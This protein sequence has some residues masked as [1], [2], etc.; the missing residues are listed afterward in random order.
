[1]SFSSVAKVWFVVS[2]GVLGVMYGTVANQWNVFPSPQMRTA[3]NQAEVQFGLESPG[4]TWSRTYDREGVR[5]LDPE[6]VQSGLRFI[7]TTWEAGA[8]EPSLTLMGRDGTVVH[9]WT[10]NRK[11]LFP[12][13]QENV[14]RAELHGSYLLPNG[15]VVFNLDYVGTVRM[16]ACGDVRWTLK[17]KN[18][19]SIA[20][21]EDGSFWIP[22]VSRG[23]TKSYPGLENPWVD[24]ILHVSGEGEILD[25]I[26]VLDVVYQ[27]NLE[28]YIAKSRA[29]ELGDVTHLND[30]EPL[31]PALA[32]EYPSF[33]AGD[34]VVSLKRQDLVFVF[35]PESLEVKWHVRSPF[36]G[37][38]DPDFT[39]GGWIGLFDNNVDGTKKGKMLGGSRIVSFQPHT[40]STRVRFPTPKSDLFYT[41]TQGKWQDLK[42]GNMLL[43][44]TA[45]GR[46][47]EVGPDGR[48][49]WEFVEPGASLTKASLHDITRSDVD[50]WPCTS[51][52]TSGSPER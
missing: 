49:V 48:S 8:G 15:D 40:D 6:N 3:W 50:A 1:M 52:D 11:E 34:L 39:G 12:D 28:R 29:T 23:D 47:V 51:V 31:P 21:G 26:R 22:A 38:H 36:I 45:A 35:D 41:E 13:A 10:I 5:V 20:R 37:Q 24:R 43:A 44:E 4:N 16:D 46:V 17:E 19:H 32:S 42:N 33:A 25:D 30:V 7:A 14:E 9:K 18:H 27:N 2:V